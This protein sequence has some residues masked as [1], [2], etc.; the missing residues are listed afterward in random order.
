M[1]DYNKCCVYVV[2]GKLARK[3]D[4]VGVFHMYDEELNSIVVNE[5]HNCCDS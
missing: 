4:K 2:P 3:D 5:L 1:K